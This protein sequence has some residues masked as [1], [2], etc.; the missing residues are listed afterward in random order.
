MKNI[1]IIGNGSIGQ[2]LIAEVRARDDVSLSFVLVRDRAKAIASG[3]PE[4]VVIDD[5]ALIEGRPLDLAIEASLPETS[6]ALAPS[7]LARADFCAFSCTALADPATETAIRAATAASGRR[8]FIPHGAVVGM[9][10]LVDA[11]EIIESVTITTTKS[12]KS[13][14]LDPETSGTIFEGSAREA[15]RRFPRNVNVHA[16][17]ALA[18]LGFERTLS[19]IVAVPGQVEN[20]HRIEVTGAG[21]AWDLRISSRSLGGVTGSYTPKSAVGSLRRI[22]GG[23]GVTAV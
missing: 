8:M 23:R 9:D 7:L 15:C 20:M 16:C 1:G 14:G 19:R 21:L 4:A 12:G 11:G 10:G 22:L 17:V 6:A 5:P 3:L 13:L 18:G 2:A